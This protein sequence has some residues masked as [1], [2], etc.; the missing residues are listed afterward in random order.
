MTED[1]YT[2]LLDDYVDE[3]LPL[4]EHAELERH[5]E[6]CDACRAQVS[7]LQELLALAADLP[8]RIAPSRDLWDDIDARLDAP[9]AAPA[10]LP[11]RR[12][13]LAAAALVTITAGAT[14]WLVLP[15][16]TAPVPAVV[17]DAVRQ[18]AAGPAWQ[19]DFE[20]ASASLQAALDERRDQLDPDAVRTIEENLALIDRAIRECEEAL[21]ASPDHP[22]L[23]KAL[24]ASWQRRIDLL[25]LAAS[26]PTAS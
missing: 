10:A 19:A 15:D 7:A 2:A 23:Q 25:E 6:A 24:L 18:P 14:T 16:A 5:L 13:A 8:P 3:L 11:W 22:G 21:G 17:A 9:T 4:D 1:R 26:L 12:L 20:H